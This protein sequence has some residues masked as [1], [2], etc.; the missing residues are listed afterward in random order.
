MEKNLPNTLKYAFMGLAALAVIARVVPGD[1]VRDSTA[2]RLVMML[3]GGALIYLGFRTLRKKRLIE[4]VPRSRIRS[5]AMGFAE[6]TGR[7]GAAPLLTSP[8]TGL[9]CV[10]FRFIV[11]KRVSRSQ[12]RSNW[13]T[14]E[15]GSS[16]EPFRLTDP[17]GMLLVDPA[18]ADLELAISHREIIRDGSFFSS[19]KRRTEWR[20]SPGQTLYILGTVRRATPAGPAGRPAT[21]D[22]PMIGRGEGETTFVISDR[23][24]R[25]TARR[26]GLQA[27]VA[28]VV[29]IL[30]LCAPFLPMLGR[31]GLL[32]GVGIGD[33]VRSIP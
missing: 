24:E 18:G 19:T 15:K 10:F 5:V 21:P 33:V 29:G 6:V 20:I 32:P 27:A 14:I 9:P 8:F 11:E 22:P 31:A 2:G 12:G 25:T 1:A 23:G 4:D 13:Q 28:L 30:M 26:L 3:G 16:T 7:A 17:T